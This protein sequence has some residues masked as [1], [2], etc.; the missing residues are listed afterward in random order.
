MA[1]EQGTA[2][3][4][5]LGRL[6]PRI[7]VSRNVIPRR[8]TGLSCLEQHI[9]EGENPVFGRRFPGTRRFPRVGLFGIA[10]QKAWYTP[11]KAKYWHETDSEQVP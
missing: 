9:G 8:T 10:A 5:N 6:R 3:I 4:L 11:R 7:V 1:N 2:Q